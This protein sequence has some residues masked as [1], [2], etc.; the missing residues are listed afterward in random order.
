MFF[1]ESLL[2]VTFDDG[3]RPCIAV[4]PVGTRPDLDSSIDLVVPAV[5]LNEQ[6]QRGRNR[7][8]LLPFVGTACK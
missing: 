5:R 8:R 7:R 2:D 1:Y 3:K 6:R 4:F